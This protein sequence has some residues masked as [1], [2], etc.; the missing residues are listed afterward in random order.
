M[1]KR[2]TKREMFTQIMNH[3]TDPTEIAFI[4]HE[5]ELLDNKKS[6]SRKLTQTQKDNESFK[7]DILNFLTTDKGYTI[8]EIQSNVPSVENLTNQ[9][10]SALLTQLINS[11][12]V[13]KNYEK[14]KAYFFK[15]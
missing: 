2:I 8:T 13:V 3:L 10:V 15:A 5:L 6:T 1:T 4:E 14:R 7:V 12:M 9:R 11:G